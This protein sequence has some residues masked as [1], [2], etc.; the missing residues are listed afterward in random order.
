MKTVKKPKSKPK[1]IK[2]SDVRKSIE[3][4]KREIAEFFG[5]PK[6]I[7]LCP[8]CTRKGPRHLCQECAELSHDAPKKRKLPVPASCESKAASDAD[9][10]LR[11][12][13][14]ERSV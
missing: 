7:K 13:A 10:L 9:E 5:K 4:R 1:I 6:A 11:R 14:R 8:T 3:K 2:L 12:I